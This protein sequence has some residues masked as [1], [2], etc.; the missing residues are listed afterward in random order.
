MR[1]Y[2]AAFYMRLKS[3]NDIRMSRH[4]NWWGVR[5]AWCRRLRT[6]TARLRRQWLRTSLTSASL[7]GM[8]ATVMHESIV[9]GG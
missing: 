7:F 3:N 4:G 8:W 9:S 2:P 1:C 5:C 6:K